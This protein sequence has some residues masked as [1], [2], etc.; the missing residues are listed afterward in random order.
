MLPNVNAIVKIN[1]I[2][3]VTLIKV[4]LCHINNYSILIKSIKK[5]S[6]ELADSIVKASEAMYKNASQREMMLQGVNACEQAW[7]SVISILRMDSVSIKFNF[8]VL[9]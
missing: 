8:L 7:V 5:M 3:Y 2:I 1:I 4:V 6:E 9:F